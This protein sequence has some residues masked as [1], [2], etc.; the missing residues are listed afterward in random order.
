MVVFSP[1]EQKISPSWDSM[2]CWQIDSPRPVLFF[3]AFMLKKGSNI[4]STIRIDENV[5]RDSQN[6]KIRESDF[7]LEISG[8]ARTLSPLPTLC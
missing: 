2:M 7:P 1:L 5:N 8:R 3:P 4:F 6:E